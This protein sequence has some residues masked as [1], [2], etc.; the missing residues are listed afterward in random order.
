M[1]DPADSLSA[2]EPLATDEMSGPGWSDVGK[3]TAALPLAVQ[4]QRRTECIEEWDSAQCRSQTETNLSKS[5]PRTSEQLRELCNTAS[6]RVTELRAM[7]TLSKS[8]DRGTYVSYANSDLCDTSS[9]C[10]V[11]VSLC[12]K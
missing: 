1:S 6:S 3:C 10:V 7:R 9:V 8:N 5:N 2:H 11:S 12:Y 4:L